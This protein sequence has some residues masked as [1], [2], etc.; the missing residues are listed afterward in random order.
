MNEPTPED[1]LK[2]LFDRQRTSDHEQAPAFHAM[3]T[4][5][6]RATPPTSSPLP[7]AWRSALLGTAAL[8]LVLTTLLSLHHPESAPAISHDALAR[9]LDQIDAALQKSLAAQDALT[10]GQS[11]T[12][13]LLHPTHNE[14]TP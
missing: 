1:D 3:R 5:A 14:N 4:Q 11:P 12:D 2:A 10:A 13:F 6:L 8:V 9:E 7:F